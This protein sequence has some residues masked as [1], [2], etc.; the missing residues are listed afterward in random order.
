M[1]L[2]YKAKTKYGTI[3]RI[4]M[5]SLSLYHT[6]PK[7]SSILLAMGMAFSHV[8][9]RNDERHTSVVLWGESSL[10]IRKAYHRRL[11]CGGGRSYWTVQ[12]P[13]I[14]C[15]R[16]R[17]L[18]MTNRNPKALSARERAVGSYNKN[19]IHNAWKVEKAKITIR[20]TSRTY[21]LSSM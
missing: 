18:M 21:Q 10:V 1:Q 13:T 4:Q 20:E 19:N 16:L 14:C 9:P 3:N 15:D 5:V 11:A 17:G 8:P 12:A 2:L 7:R 6:V